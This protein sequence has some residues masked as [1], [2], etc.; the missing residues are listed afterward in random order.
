MR[1]GSGA[2]AGR[3]RFS[4]PPADVLART[5]DAKLPATPGSKAQSPTKVVTSY[6]L[7]TKQQQLAEPPHARN[8][9]PQDSRPATPEMPANLPSLEEMTQQLLADA[10]A[11]AAADCSAGV[12]IS[13]R[14]DS[15]GHG[16]Y[17]SPSPAPGVDA[18]LYRPLTAPAVRNTSHN[19]LSMERNTE[20][21][22]HHH[23]SRPHNKFTDLPESVTARPNTTSPASNYCAWVEGQQNHF[24]VASQQVPQD[25]GP[26]ADVIRKQQEIHSVAYYELCRQVAVHCQERGRLM[27]ELWTSAQDL[28]AAA[29]RDREIA[30]KEAFEA[31]GKADQLVSRFVVEVADGKRVNAQ[32]EQANKELVVQTSKQR[33]E[34][35]GLHQ[36]HDIVRHRLESYIKEDTTVK[37]KTLEGR[38]AQLQA[39]EEGLR[40]QVDEGQAQIRELSAQLASTQEKLQAREKELTQL[41]SEQPALTPRPTRELGLLGD[42]IPEE[43]AMMMVNDAL[44]RNMHPEELHRLLIGRGT[45]AQVPRSYF[46]A[47][48]TLRDMFRQAEADAAAKAEYDAK[49]ARLP[50]NATIAMPPLSASVSQGALISCMRT[51]NLA[52]LKD[53][54]PADTLAIV[55]SAIQHNIDP[56]S[57][58]ALLNGCISE[59]GYDITPFRE[60]G[61]LLSN[62]GEGHKVLGGPITDALLAAKMSTAQQMDKLKA[63]S[64]GQGREIVRLK[65]TLADLQRLHA[66]EAQFME[67]KALAR[68]KRRVEMKPTP[69]QEFLATTW[70][71]E[72][73]GLG[74]SELLPKFLRVSGKVRY[75]RIPKVDCK[76][77]AREIW[78][79]KAA[80]DKER[81]ARSALG[82]YI[83]TYLFRKYGEPTQVNITCYSLLWSL[84][85]YRADIECNLFLQI[86]IGMIDEDQFFA[87][88]RQQRDVLAML[89]SVDKAANSKVTGWLT[90]KELQVAIKGFYAFKTAERFEDLFDALDGDCPANIVNYASLFQEDAELSQTMF[91][92]ALR[93]QFLEEQ[94]ELLDRIEDF[95]LEVAF[96]FNTDK[97]G[98]KGLQMALQR[99]SPQMDKAEAGLFV[100]RAFGP[101]ASQPGAVVL[102]AD[103]MRAIRLGMRPEA[104]AATSFVSTSLMQAVGAANRFKGQAAATA[105]RGSVSDIQPQGSLT[106]SPPSTLRRGTI[107]G[108]SSPPQTASP[109]LTQ[110]RSPNAAGH[111]TTD[112]GGSPTFTPRSDSPPIA[113]PA[114]DASGSP[115]TGAGKGHNRRTTLAG[116]QQGGPAELLSLDNSPRHRRSA[117]LMQNQSR[118]GLPPAPLTHSNLLN[119]SMATFSPTQSPTRAHHDSIFS[120]RQ[121]PGAPSD[122]PLSLDE[123]FSRI[124][125]GRD[126][127]TS[128]S[129]A[130]FGQA[131]A[132]RL[133]HR[134]SIAASV[135]A[136]R[137]VSGASALSH[138]SSL[139]VLEGA[140]RRSSAVGERTG[141]GSRRA[142]HAGRPDRGGPRL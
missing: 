36:E 139:G 62:I 3:P 113:S 136:L 29:L 31:A 5:V 48:G 141:G 112:G 90:K 110:R 84:Y 127:T 106:R 93:G 105:R 50:S 142:S 96:E 129:P 97:L 114:S 108:N 47:A 28:L 125:G 1:P 122:Q 18:L 46:L 42:L 6:E 49:V 34:L 134:A 130:G 10:E 53:R 88:K 43:W 91:V 27:A 59:S 68:R 4:T 126:G 86:A 58:A 74:P 89:T 66:E 61:G 7:W 60:L 35:E 38:V 57:L 73:V 2:H 9:H 26:T 118:F 19:V 79:G 94:L 85:Q 12:D 138:A 121:S 99:A 77:L 101:R 37:A 80:Y 128:N 107:S 135:P 123:A 116:G 32:L 95:V 76:V 65:K 64:K 98:V 117:S 70:G 11:A 51:Q 137:T 115:R 132:G 120:D 16:R 14:H 92:E 78:A 104:S 100:E 111:R 30:R 17:P 124:N 119:V 33:S 72:F 22:G 103:I 82:D 69:V 109:P 131:P 45:K 41:Q 21:P 52:V 39:V 71:D 8:P 56:E 23:D 54:L 24:D 140:S 44:S 75:K 20:W 83:Y 133:G 87:D 63:F 67:A 40:M 102:V 13:Y 15:P 25:G 55:G 81:A